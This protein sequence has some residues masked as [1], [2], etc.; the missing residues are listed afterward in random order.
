M[1]A[2]LFP[3]PYFLKDDVMQLAP[4]HI[5]AVFDELQL[6]NEVLAPG[7]RALELGCGK[8]EKTRLI[9]QGGKAD[10][11]LALEV[12]QIQHEKNMQVSDLPT[13]RFALGGAQ[14]IP[15][16]DASFD[17]VMM[18]KSLH[19]V[20]LV[21]MDG[22]LE[23]IC[24]VLKPG[25]LAYLS[26]PIFAGDYNEIMR[27]FHD[28][29]QVRKAAFD[30]VKRAVDAG[31]MALVRQVFFKTPIRFRDFAQ[32]DRGVLNVSHTSHRLSP[33]LHD[34]VREKF[35]RHMTPDGARFEVPI[36]VDLLRKDV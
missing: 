21:E 20:P 7:A 27:L 14:D 12:D 17:I 1:N 13:V 16:E 4:A 35:E 32:F 33:Q 10:F 25:G 18:F 31:R 3:V 19:H 36:R 29:E 11:I 26:E 2:R 6:V 30:A 9:A 5:D 15:A 28:E 24:R 22:A 23:E 8:A 34:E